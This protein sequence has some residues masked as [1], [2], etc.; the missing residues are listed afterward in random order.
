MTRKD[1][2]ICEVEYTSR[3]ELLVYLVSHPRYWTANSWNSSTSFAHRVKLD[4]LCLT[5]EEDEGALA[6]LESDVWG[7]AIKGLIRDFNDDTGNRYDIGQNGRSGGYLVLYPISDGKIYPVGSG[8]KD[9]YEDYTDEDLLELVKD[10]QMFDEAVLRITD[11]FAELCGKT[12][13]EEIEIQVPKKIKRLKGKDGFDL[14]KYVAEITGI[15]L[16][17]EEEDNG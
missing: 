1:K 12:E 13:L 2:Y 15:G 10:V 11:T 16:S 9:F 17:E 6:V 8:D 7:E 4:D 3:E 5:A 14:D